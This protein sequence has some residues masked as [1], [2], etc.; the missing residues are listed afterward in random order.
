MME[1]NKTGHISGNELDQLLNRAFLELDFEKPENKEMLDSIAQQTLTK[2]SRHTFLFAR[3]LNSIFFLLSLLIFVSS[4]TR[5]FNSVGS[6]KIQRVSTSIPSK[7]NNN[8][9]RKNFPNTLARSVANNSSTKEP[10]QLVTPI[11]VSKG[12]RKDKLKNIQSSNPFAAVK[13]EHLS[14]SG[15]Q[16]QS[17]KS[18]VANIITPADKT[19]A[20]DILQASLRATTGQEQAAS[21][22]T[23]KI[24]DAQKA[25]KKANQP[26]QH[27][28]KMEND[29]KRV[30]YAVR[31]KQG[32]LKRFK[33]QD[34]WGRKQGFL[35][36]GKRRN[37][38]GRRK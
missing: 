26:S 19:G 15:N 3:W 9:F 31:R 14:T 18:S 8:P 17:E 29:N 36:W 5:Y 1:K 34:K 23:P 2:N 21:Q 27:Y 6:Q 25:R 38:W 7:Q 35:K 28:V 20:N 22:S 37:R 11:A 4:F 33:T 10:A 24:N 30:K 12:N 13:S 16:M 32:L